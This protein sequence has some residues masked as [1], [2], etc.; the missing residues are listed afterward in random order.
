MQNTLKYSLLISV[1][2]GEK[3]EYLDECLASI[4]AQSYPSD[5]VVLICDGELTQSLNNVIEKYV[6]NYGKIF[7]VVRLE[8]NIGTGGAA[9]IGLNAC[10]HSLIIKTD[11]DDISRVDRCSKQISMF[12]ADSSL[13]MAGGFIQEFDSDTKENIA[14]K[15]VPL[16]HN[17]IYKYAKR[18]NP[19][20]NPTIA[21]KKADALEIGGY[22]EDK[23]C[24]DYDFVCR[25]LMA[26]K[27][28]AN[29]SDVLLDYRVTSGNYNRRKN[30]RNTKAFI[31]VRWRNFRSGFSN[32]FDFLTPCIMQLIIFI[33]PAKLTGLI[34]KKL[35]RR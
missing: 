13:S 11:S 17:E 33:L 34:Y 31:G 12:E 16:N 6:N 21:I 30:W 9:N 8:K 32:F 23:R 22:S 3:S 10:K 27:K 26:G 14:I 20:N 7:N 15:E 1:Y 4:F 19:I 24:E 25:M 18:R 29:T 28:A 35:L 2:K 5:D